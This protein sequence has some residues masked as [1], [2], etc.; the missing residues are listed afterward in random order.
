MKVE[1]IK[2]ECLEG[3]KWLRLLF[4]AVFAVASYFI[5]PL[6]WI[7]S[8]FQFIYHLVT[9]KTCTFLIPFTQTL[10]QYTSDIIAYLCFN[11]EDKPFPFSEWPSKTS[12]V[13]AKPNKSKS[14]EKKS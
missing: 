11:R 9:G 2:Q 4:M 7:I 8:S 13:C 10:S 5:I 12:E 3:R 6:V 14:G 1:E